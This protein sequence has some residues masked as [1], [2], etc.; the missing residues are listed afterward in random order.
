MNG[1]SFVSHTDRG[2]PI[3]LPM[4]RNQPKPTRTLGL[5]KR[6]SMMGVIETAP[7]FPEPT[8]AMLEAG[9]RELLRHDSRFD[10]DETVA[11]NIFV[12]MWNAWVDERWPGPSA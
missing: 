7:D 10:S 8:P 3:V 2:Q 4:R 9:A 1:G 5:R 11:Y 6:E 12:A